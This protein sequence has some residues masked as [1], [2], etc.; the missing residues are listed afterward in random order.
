ME[1]DDS[2]CVT[3]GNPPIDQSNC[4]TGDRVTQQSRH[5]VPLSTSGLAPIS[6]I[7][8]DSN[9]PLVD[10]HNNLSEDKTNKDIMLGD[11]ITCVRIAYS[12]GFV[13]V[14]AIIGIKVTNEIC[15]H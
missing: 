13:S 9:S 14:L 15:R 12:V 8:D 2:C 3:D 7:P 5:R 1:I 4:C 10:T 6:Q 11:L